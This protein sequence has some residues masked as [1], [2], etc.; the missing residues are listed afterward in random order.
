MAD[1]DDDHATTDL[2]PC[3][4][5]E[6]TV[7]VWNV[8]ML[9]QKAPMPGRG[10]GCVV[11]GLPSDGALAVICNA[12]AP[13]LAHGDPVPKLRFACRGYPAS[14]GRVPIATLTGTHDHDITR[15]PTSDT[16][17]APDDD[18]PNDYGDERGLDED[19]D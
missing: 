11:C 13:E 15:H 14:D 3:C 10:W 9:R 4:V 5:C 16:W 2:G 12:C 19:A 6:S 8:L 17:G 18:D 1:D 7:D